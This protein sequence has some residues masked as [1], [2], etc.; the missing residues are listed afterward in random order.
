VTPARSSHKA[1]HHDCD[2]KARSLAAMKLLEEDIPGGIS[3]SRIETRSSQGHHPPFRQSPA[4][5]DE[6]LEMDLT[7][8]VVADMT[9]ETRAPQ[10]RRSLNSMHAQHSAIP[11][12]GPYQRAMGLPISTGGP[13]GAVN[14]RDAKPCSPRPGCR[15]SNPEWI[16]SS[17]E[18]SQAYEERQVCLHNDIIAPD[19]NLPR[20]R[21]SSRQH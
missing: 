11:A 3:H 16:R 10:R 4:L 7:L 18:E 15:S 20:S 6:T 5:P 1:P 17:P 9:A 8:P 2:D 12:I 21:R 13:E 19:D 14:R